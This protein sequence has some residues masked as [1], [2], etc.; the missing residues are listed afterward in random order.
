MILKSSNLKLEDVILYPIIYGYEY[1]YDH[2]I[3]GDNLSHYL[4]DVNIVKIAF[5]KTE[6]QTTHTFKFMCQNEHL[7]KNLG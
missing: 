1:G 3:F 5:I 4:Y 2:I 7:S 6:P